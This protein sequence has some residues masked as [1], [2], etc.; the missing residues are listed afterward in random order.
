[1][2]KITKEDLISEVKSACIKIGFNPELATKELLALINE[3]GIIDYYITTC[4][5]TKMFPNT[6]MDVWILCKKVLFDY[7]IQKGGSIYHVVLLDDI[8]KIAEEIQE[9]FAVVS[10]YAGSLVGLACFAKLDQ[11]DRLRKFF[12]N[13]KEELIK[14]R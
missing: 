4:I 1:M 2:S 6:L 3:L 5:P 10:I 12:I 9:G 8:V 13:L 11:R 14:G 7:E